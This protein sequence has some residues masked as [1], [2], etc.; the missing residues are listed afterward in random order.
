MLPG[1]GVLGGLMIEV[2]S[3][4]IDAIV[5]GKTLESE[6]NRMLKHCIM[7]KFQMAF[8]ACEVVEGSERIDVAVLTLEDA[9]I[10]VG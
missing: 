1:Q 8:G 6:I 9:T 3:V 5:T 7:L 2:G 10:P 4:A